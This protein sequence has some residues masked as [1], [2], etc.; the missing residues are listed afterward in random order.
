ML[1]NILPIGSVIKLK[2]AEKLI[3]IFGIMQT[4][5]SID[6]SA[7]KYDYI[8]VTYPVGY[9]SPKLFLGFD[10]DQ[11]ETIIFKGYENDDYKNL[12]ST[13]KMANFI[14]ENRDKINKIISETDQQ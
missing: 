9:L 3:M 7:V 11:I 5:T 4:V 8:G 14:A 13:L 12:I 6:G 10:H 1:D 2:Y